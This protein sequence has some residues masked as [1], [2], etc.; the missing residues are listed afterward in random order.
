MNEQNKQQIQQGF[1]YGTYVAQKE[2]E[3]AALCIQYYKEQ[4]EVAQTLG[5]STVIFLDTNVLLG[6]YQMPL[7]ARTALYE[8]LKENKERVYICDQVRR[9]FIKHKKNVQRVYARQLTL[10]R[11]TAPQKAIVDKIV[12]F[13]EENEDVLEAY[14][15]FKEDLL[16]VE[17]NS[18]Q[19]LDALQTMAKEQARSYKALLY[20]DN[21]DALWMDFQHLE[22]LS[23]K[24]YRFLKRE[25]DALSKEIP[26]TT[27]KGFANPIEAYL[28]Q[29]P[30]KVFPGIGDIHKK[31][32]YP[33]GDYCIFHE[34]MKWR[35]NASSEQLLVF[36]TND[37]TK[38]DW[39]DINKRAY[40]HYLEN[41]YQNTGHIF[42]ILH[43]EDIFSNVLQTPCA[44]LVHSTD[45][46]EDAEKVFWSKQPANLTVQALQHLLQ[47]LYPNR[48]VV[49]EPEDFWMDLL[50][51]LKQDFG[52]DNL[53]QL[54]IDLIEHYH[55]LVELELGRYQIHDQVDALERTLELIYD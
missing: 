33:Y 40:V 32:K 49:D 43:A 41:F 44:H 3:H 8:F 13:L 46:W 2:G 29:N 25:F 14:P 27:P 5:Q 18:H 12:D 35:A 48:A 19:I 4:L 45:I 34:M 38:S 37:V 20:E 36:L 6:Y 52:I 42:Y 47:E 51:D 15:D 30:T 24:E 55:L 23:K 53:W 1:S 31:A 22:P 54:K 28:Y 10:Q 11:P 17:K 9:E 26:N 21:L 50:Y 7:L 39:V 16:K